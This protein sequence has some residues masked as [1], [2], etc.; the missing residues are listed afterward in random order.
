MVQSDCYDATRILFVCKENKNKDFIQQFVSSASV[1]HHTDN[2]HCFRS[3]QSVENVSVRCGWHRTA[4][5]ICV[6]RILSKMKLRWHRGDELLNKVVIFI[7]FAYKKYPRPFIKFILNHWWQM[8]YFDDAFHSFLCLDSVI[9]LVVNGTDTNLPV[10]IQNILIVFRR[11]TKLLWVWN[12][13]GVS[14]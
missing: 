2:L 12:Y 6:Q 10:F 1:W 5:A 9:Y 7:F 14:D 3:N 8:D 11:R 13:M 4:H